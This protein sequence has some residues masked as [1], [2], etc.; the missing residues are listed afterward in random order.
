MVV[1][2]PRDDE[3]LRR[4]MLTAHEYGAGPIAI[5]FPR[6]TAV[7][8]SS[9]AERDAVPIGKGEVLRRGADA[10]IVAVGSMVTTALAASEI[11]L[12]S[13]ISVSV[14]DAKFVKP[15]DSDLLMSLAGES[16]TI[17]FALE[18]NAR[19][20]G[21]GE[22]ILEF[23]SDRAPG[24]RVVTIGLPDRFVPHGRREE[25][26]EEVGM[27]A[28]AVAAEIVRVAGSRAKTGHGGSR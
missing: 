1:M 27:S 22:A 12:H 14:I 25:L 17:V 9:C 26:L 2:A 8:G 15:L 16:S 18:E 6:G 20:G 7:A 19:S 28:E 10:A 5:R 23:F 11:L 3:E 4:M 13:G 21:F 24:T